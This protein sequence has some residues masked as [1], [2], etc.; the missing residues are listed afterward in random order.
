MA[1]SNAPDIPTRTLTGFFGDSDRSGYQR[2]YFTRDRGYHAEFRAEDVVA[3]APG[4]SD[5]QPL[6]GAM[7]VTLR[8]GASME[9]GKPGGGGG[10]DDEFDL[11]VQPGDATPAEARNAPAQ[12]SD[13]CADGCP[14][15]G[16][17]DT[18]CDQAT[19]RDTCF[20]PQTCEGETCQGHTCDGGATCGGHTC[21]GGDTCQGPECVPEEP[22]GTGTCDGQT[23]E[24]GPTC[25]G[26]NTCDGGNTCAHTCQT[27]DTQ[28]EETRCIRCEPVQTAGGHTCIG[29]TECNPD[30]CLIE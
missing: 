2:L 30:T 20:P 14:P 11:D 1:R 8:G 6:A 15:P 18:Q 28:C 7:Q 4:P 26:G 13:S 25:E 17:E 19:C 5:V 12:L 22:H 23:C 24:G 3:T 29:V 10:S 9:Y 27:C 21:D 16:T